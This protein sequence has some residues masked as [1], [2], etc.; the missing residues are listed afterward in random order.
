MIEVFT[1]NIPNQNKGISVLKK[2]K[3]NFPK[4]NISFDIERTIINYP[5]DHSILRAEGNTILVENF[6]KEV[7][8]LGFEC[9]ILEDKVCRKQKEI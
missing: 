1:T 2:L 3:K 7:N 6:I 8:T 9:D 5:C 4:L